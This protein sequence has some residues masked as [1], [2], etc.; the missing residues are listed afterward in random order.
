MPYRF[1]LRDASLTE[2]LRRIASEQI[3]RVQTSLADDAAA[4]E[5]V[6][7][8]RKSVKK[9]RALLR[10]LSPGLGDVQPAE[11]IVLR[12]AGRALAHRRDASVRLETFDKLTGDL[13]SGSDEN[14]ALLALRAHLVAEATMPPTPLPDLRSLFDSLALR[15]SGWEVRGNE[16]RLLTEGLSDTRSRARRAMR[17]ARDDRNADALHDWR[18]RAKDHWYQARL[19]Q[20]VWPELMTATINEAGQL[21]E[22]LGDHN[23]LSVLRAHIGA[24]GDDIARPEIRALLE[25]RI[26]EAQDGVE[27]L[28]FPLGA[29]LFAGDPDEMAALWVKWWRLWRAQLD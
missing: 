14:P 13:L 1:D 21:G 24:L 4:A 28:A 20:P 3:D 11:N 17:A 10:L 6:H 7:N 23:D 2:A 5:S 25:T 22:M 27:A 12:D 19:L 18:K 29:R 15:A 9:L 16:R 26:R 8:T